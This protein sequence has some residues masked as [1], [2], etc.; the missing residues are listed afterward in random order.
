MAKKV[1]VIADASPLIA[2]ALIDRLPLLQALF[3]AVKVV[4]A[5]YQE[6]MT[7]TFEQTEHAIANAVQ[8]GW[9][10]LVTEDVPV[11][12][13][14]PAAAMLHWMHLDPGEAAGISFAM[15]APSQHT[16]LIDELAGRGVCQTLGLHRMGTAAVIGLAKE[17]GLISSAKVELA[18]LHAAGFWMS[19]HLVRKVLARVGE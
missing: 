3:G 10:E 16:V 13:A 14:L 19:A 7:G 1:T 18:R 8:Q 5:V 15:R 17:R 6:V 2:L 4:P 12:Q 11:F 9:L